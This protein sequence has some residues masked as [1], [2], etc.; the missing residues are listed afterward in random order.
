[1]KIRGSLSDELTAAHVAGWA[2][3][4][5]AVKGSLRFGSGQRKRR[6]PKWF[7]FF[8]Y[9]ILLKSTLPP[10]FPKLRGFLPPNFS[11]V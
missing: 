8:V 4:W 11:E 2:Y 1:M 10:G 3:F 5:Q 9:R 6:P 7:C